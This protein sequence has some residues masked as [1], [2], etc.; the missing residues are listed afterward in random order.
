MHDLPSGAGKSWC[1]ACPSCARALAALDPATLVCCDEAAAQTVRD[2]Y[3]DDLAELQSFQEAMLEPGYV[4]SVHGVR[5]LALG[6]FASALSD[7]RQKQLMWARL[8]QIP[9]LGEPF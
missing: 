7:Q 6:G 3:A 8:K 9:P 2:A 1:A 5:V 4:V